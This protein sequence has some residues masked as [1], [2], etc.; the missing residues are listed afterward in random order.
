MSHTALRQLR[1]HRC[2]QQGSTHGART[3]Q[4]HPA[5]GA[6]VPCTVEPRPIATKHLDGAGA[7]Q[8]WF[9]TGVLGEGIA[10]E[11]LHKRHKQG[12]LNT[13]LEERSRGLNISL[14][15]R[16]GEFRREAGQEFANT[17]PFAS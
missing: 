13:S 11:E 14:G 16:G 1:R 15:Q 5:R 17:I 6:P 8:N 9:L 3:R 10:E 4:P 12:V 2:F 7:R